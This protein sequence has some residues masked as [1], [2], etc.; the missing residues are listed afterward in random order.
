VEEATD[1]YARELL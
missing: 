1:F